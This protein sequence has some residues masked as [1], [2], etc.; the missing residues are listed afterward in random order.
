MNRLTY[1][2]S[3][4]LGLIVIYW[5]MLTNYV[6]I[7][8]HRSIAHRA[9]TL[10]RWWIL[11][12]TALSNMFTIYVN[13]RVWVAEHRLHHAHSDSDKDPDKQPNQTF[14]PWFAYLLL[15]NPSPDEPH[16]VQV[17]RDKIFDS[18][19]MRFFSNWKGKVWSEITGFT[20]PF[21]AFRTIAGTFAYWLGIRIGGLSVKAIQ[22]Y[23]AHSAQDGWG[24]R[25]YEL[26]DGSSNIRHPFASWVSAGESLQNN[27]HAKPTLPIHAHR[28]DEWDAGYSVVKLLDMV[29]LVT[30]PAGRRAAMYQP[31]ASKLA[32]EGAIED[33]LG[34][35]AK[36]S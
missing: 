13:P 29:G 31:K 6:S 10:P 23:F 16:L 1:D 34:E 5:F 30:M 24:Y 14:W 11:T 27:H 3:A 25:T 4:T 22:S 15:H 21:L 7:A 20:L 35:L 19:I 8:L 18:W 9:F 32:L 26:P 12:I 36:T 17:S 33:P 2:I 28:P